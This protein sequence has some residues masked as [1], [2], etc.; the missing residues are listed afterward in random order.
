MNPDDIGCRE[1]IS[2]AGEEGCVILKSK[3]A[4]IGF[5]QQIRFNCR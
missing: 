2:Y 4:T 1:A 5:V 3:V